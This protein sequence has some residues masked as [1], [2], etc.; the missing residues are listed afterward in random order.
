ML[1]GSDLVLDSKKMRTVA[2]VVDNQMNIIR[3]CFES[4]R[5]DAT[6]LKGNDWEGDSS[7][8]YYESMKK[9]CSDQPLDGVIS[10]GIIVQT[11]KDYVSKLNDAADMYEA[12]EKKLKARIEALPVDVFGV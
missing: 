2:K 10:A 12:N 11:L 1:A 3:S 5:N 8:S 9:L 7:E 6:G 4:I